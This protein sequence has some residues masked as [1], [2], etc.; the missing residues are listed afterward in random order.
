MDRLRLLTTLI[1]EFTPARG[2]RQ[3]GLHQWDVLEHSLE[4]VAALERFADVMRQHSEQV[5]TNE[6]GDLAPLRTLL[7]EAERQGI[8]TRADLTSPVMKLAALLHDIGKPVTHAIDNEGNIHF[9]HHPQAGVPLAQTIMQRMSASVHDRRL[10]QQVVANHM[11]PGQLSSGTLTQRAIRRYFVDLGPVGI[12]VALVSLA[13]H[14]AM[15]GLQPLTEHWTNHLTTVVALLH[16]YI[17]ER[18]RIMPPRLLQADEL[19]S[20]LKLT[21]GPIIG[22]LLEAIAEAQAE[23]SIHSKED[24]LWLAHEKL[25]QDAV[26]EPSS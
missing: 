9:Y 15:R 10:V 18:Q 13:D 20:R 25:Q 23:G 11:R 26:Q 1:P 4:A 12:N 21:P 19:I 7:D 16:T 17:R 5:A 2:M 22:Q 3:P 6:M 14:L 8:F 24:A